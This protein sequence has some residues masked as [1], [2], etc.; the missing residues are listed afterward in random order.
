MLPLIAEPDD[1]EAKLGSENLLVI[2]VSKTDIYAQM[3]IP[4]ALHIDYPLIVSA[5]PPIAGLIPDISHLNRVFSELGI[6]GDTHV[7]AYDDEGGG[8]ACRLLWTLYICGHKK[9]SLL[10]GGLHAWSNEG[11]EMNHEPVSALKSENTFSQ[12]DEGVADKEYVL[13]RL[14]NKD[15]AL[16][17]ARSPDEFWGV[18]KFAEKAGHIPGAVNFEWTLAIDQTRNLRLKPESELLKNLSKIGITR[19]K[20]IIAYC[21]SHHRSAHTFIMLKSLGFQRVRGY[22]GSWSDWGNSRETPVE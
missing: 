13:S 20:E 10:N 14:E 15:T 19:D 11:H 1:L 6:T 17:D 5:K 18:K 22:A 16:L 2:D 4:G 8:K 3:H 12:I 7:A 21:Q 9:I